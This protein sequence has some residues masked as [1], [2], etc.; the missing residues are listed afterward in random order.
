[1]GISALLGAINAGFIEFFDLDASRTM[2]DALR[3]DYY[4]HMSYFYGLLAVVVQP[5]MIEENEVSGLRLTQML[6]DA[7]LRDLLGRIARQRDAEQAQYDLREARA[8]HAHSVLAA[9]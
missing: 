9:P 3:V 7:S 5:L 4:T 1:M 8:V 6:D 2:D